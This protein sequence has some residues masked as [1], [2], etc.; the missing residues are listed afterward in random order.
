MKFVSYQNKKE[1]RVGLYYQDK[2]FDL[3]K[4]ASALKIKLPSTMKK[5]LE[6]ESANMKLAKKVF[7]AIKKGKIKT[8]IKYSNKNILAPVPNPTSL[9]DGYAFRQHVSTARRNRGVEMI[10]E[11]DQFPVFYFGNHNAVSGPGNVKVEDDHLKG[12]DFELE[13][14]IVIGKKGKNIPVNKADEYIAGYMIMNDLSA[15]VLQMEEMKL[16]L[17]PA[18]GKDFATT[19]GPYLVTTD[20]LDQFKVKTKFGNKYNLEMTAK[21]NGKQISRGN[22][23]QMDW[24]FAEIIERAS[25]GVTLYPGDVIGSGTVGTGCYLELNGTW[26]IE[27]KEKGS[28]H[29]PVWLQDGDE[30]ELEITGLG[31]LKNKIKKSKT[32]RS[33]LAIKKK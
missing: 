27:A 7:E 29:K 3:Q 26:A 16:N 22:V 30:I 11:F 13:C 23:N 9:R 14:A 4:A 6:G 32:N 15:R 1:E 21:H 31:V 24:T 12:C 17:G 10:P 25:Y 33:I 19:I 28:E 2:V 18:K 20:E 8:G 5:F